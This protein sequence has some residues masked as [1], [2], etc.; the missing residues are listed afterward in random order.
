MRPTIRVLSHIIKGALQFLFV[1]CLLPRVGRTLLLR[2]SA[3]RSGLGMDGFCQGALLKISMSGVTVQVFLELPPFMSFVR[4]FQNHK[5]KT[6]SGPAFP[7]K[8]TPLIFS[9]PY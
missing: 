5:L 3:P 1:P 7:T 2:L 6:H 4:T 8:S 9:L